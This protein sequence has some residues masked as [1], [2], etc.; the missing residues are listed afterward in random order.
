MMR[1]HLLL[2]PAAM[3]AAAVPQV[4]AA[5]Q[6]QALDAGLQ[7]L[8]RGQAIKPLQF[9]L[10]AA[11]FERIKSEYDVPA[12]RPTVRAWHAAGSDTWI[13][14]DQVYGLN[15]IVTYLVAVDASGKVSGLEVLTCAEGYCDLYTNEW[16]AHFTGVS[17]GK[18]QP[19][20]VVPIVSGATL[21]STHVAEGV[22]KILAIHARFL[23]PAP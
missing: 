7:R 16:R 4:C 3:V 9:T 8:A 15:D 14:L 10:N 11:Q 13:F 6:L 1:A 21:S 5:D 20:E 23:P 22:K 19:A 2:V 18:W 12:L 17:H